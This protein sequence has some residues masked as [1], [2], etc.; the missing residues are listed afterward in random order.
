MADTYRI[1]YQTEEPDLDKTGRRFVNV[2]HVSYEV[3]SGPARGTI[4]T[5]KVQNEDHTPEYI[6][7]AIRAKIAALH[8]IASL[9]EEPIG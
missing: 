1:T 9:G 7:M 5:I 3:T 2:W 6:D 4:G 8:G